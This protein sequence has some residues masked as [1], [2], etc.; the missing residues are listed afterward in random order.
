M[1]VIINTGIGN[2]KSVQNMLSRTGVKATLSSDIDEINSAEKLIMP[3]I[4]AFD[5][6]MQALQDHGLVDVLHRRVMLEKTKILGI[7]L[8][9]QML[10]SSSEEGKLPGL[11]F[12][13]GV[14]RKFS[15]SAQDGAIK[16]PHMGWNYAASS[17]QAK[18]F[19]GYDGI[20]RFYFTHSYHF[21]CADKTDVAAFTRHGIDFVSAVERGNVFGVQFHP[22]K[23]HR[24][25]FHLLK[26][27]VEC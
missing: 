3:G 6:G 4:G 10:G 23:S 26:R 16:V 7:C 25:G 24:F 12:I 18:L 5:K 2:F 21:D 15:S 11:S 27:F 17:T 9:M 8:G 14:V 22:E 20:P 13:N 19:Q 1:I